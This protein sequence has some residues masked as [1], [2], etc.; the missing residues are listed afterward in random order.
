MQMEK[1]K[2]GFKA[3]WVVLAIMGAVVFNSCDLAYAQTGQISDEI[4]VLKSGKRFVE[5]A[6]D[7]IQFSRAGSTDERELA[8]DLNKTASAASEYLNAVLTL[9]KIYDD[10]SCKED[11]DRIRPVIEAELHFYSK[12]VELLIKEA[13]LDIAQTRMPGVAAEGTRMRDDLRQAE[14]T[15]D[16]T[17]L[18]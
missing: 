15:F 1:H 7:F 5:Y 12:N 18:R 6:Q 8:M 13:N 2:F 14:S 17:K 11:R 10:L 9:L 3:R 4:V 16:S